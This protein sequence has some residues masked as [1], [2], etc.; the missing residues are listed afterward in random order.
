MLISMLRHQNNLY[1]ENKKK[2]I[3]KK[4]LGKQTDFFYSKQLFSV[5]VFQVVVEVASC[6][7]VAAA[8]NLVVPRGM[9]VREAKGLLMVVLEEGLNSTM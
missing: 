4:N 1:R 8:A 2:T 9:V 7:M 6:L 3:P 5:F